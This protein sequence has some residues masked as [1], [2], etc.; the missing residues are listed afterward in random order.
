MHFKTI[1]IKAIRKINI[2]HHFLLF[3]LKT[4]EK[5]NNAIIKIQLGI[6]IFNPVFIN[7]FS[8]Y[9]PTNSIVFR[10][11]NY[12]ILTTRKIAWGN[13][14]FPI[15]RAGIKKFAINSTRTFATLTSVFHIK[16][17][18]HT[19]RNLSTINFLGLF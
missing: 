13:V 8:C 5:I 6:N 18:N 7:L 12:A 4:N 9:S 2:C 1:T 16:L 15:A 3:V 14:L 17:L 11:V 10:A 19:P